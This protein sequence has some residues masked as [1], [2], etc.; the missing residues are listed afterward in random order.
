MRDPVRPI[1]AMRRSHM[2]GAAANGVAN[3]QNTLYR[4]RSPNSE[5]EPSRPFTPH[6]SG[7]DAP[8]WPLYG[9]WDVDSMSINGEAL[10]PLTTDTLR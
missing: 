7:P 8:R 4:S 5:P 6:D 10:P 9:I 1:S 2:P 3:G